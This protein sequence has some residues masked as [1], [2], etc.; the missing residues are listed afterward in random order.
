M[1]YRTIGI[2]CILDFS[3]DLCSHLGNFSLL[4]VCLMSSWHNRMWREIPPLPSL[5]W[6]LERMGSE[7]K[8][9]SFLLIRWA[10]NRNGC[11]ENST[12]FPPIW[13]V[14][15]RIGS[16]GKSPCFLRIWWASDRTW[17]KENISQL[18]TYL[19]GVRRVRKWRKSPNFLFDVHQIEQE[20][21]KISPLPDNW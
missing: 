19:I 5:W 2:Y 11:K 17:S 3:R 9:L 14:R 20:M 18:P 21:K 16:K 10:A 13:W 15:D 7:G 4:P 1:T 8:S 6:E 12:K